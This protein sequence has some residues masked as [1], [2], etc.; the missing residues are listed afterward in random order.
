MISTHDQNSTPKTPRSRR[1]R[2]R[3]PGVSEVAADE[4]STADASRNMEIGSRY[5]Q[6]EASIETNE[7]DES[8]ANTSFGSISFSHGAHT[9]NCSP[10]DG[11]GAIWIGADCDENLPDLDDSQPYEKNETENIIPPGQLISANIR[12]AVRLAYGR[13]KAVQQDVYELKLNIASSFNS[14]N[15][16]L[17]ESIISSTKVMVCEITTLKKELDSTLLEKRRLHNY[18]QEMKGNIRVLCRVRPPTCSSVHDFD[19]VECR[20]GGQILTVNVPTKGIDRNGRPRPPEQKL[21]SFDAVFGPSSSQPDVYAE[22][23]GFVDSAY[24]GFHCTC[25]AYGQTGSG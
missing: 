10:I 2:S 15:S 11:C 4:A 23:R 6:Q 12:D 5:S 18:I 22:V 16:M 13:S 1:G 25:I 14:F 9:M 3:T 24:D 7:M 8:R 20:R 19:S 17:R 21:F